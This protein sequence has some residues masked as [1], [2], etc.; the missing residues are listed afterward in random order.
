MR[1]KEYRHGLRSP[2]AQIS[3]R[4]PFR[5]RNG[6][7]G[8]TAYGSPPAGPIRRPDE[9]RSGAS[10]PTGRPGSDRSG[11]GRPGGRPACNPIPRHRGRRTGNRRGRRPGGH[12]CGSGT[13]EARTGSA[14]ASRRRFRRPA[15][16]TPRRWC[17]HGGRCNSRRRTRRSVRR[18]GRAVPAP[19]PPRPG[20]TG[21]AP[22]RGRRVLP[23]GP[24]WCRACSRR[25]GPDR[26]PGRPCPGGGRRWPP[27]PPRTTAERIAT[28]AR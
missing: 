23:G 15:R 26:S 21:R 3:G 6:L 19:G 28:A 2:Y 20:Q 22:A 8:G 9:G 25:T 4:A 17:R 7:S 12:R 24:R 1:S 13:A 11:R 27:P 14:G 16:R 10:S 18:P 5:S